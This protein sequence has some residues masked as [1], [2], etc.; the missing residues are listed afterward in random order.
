MDTGLILMLSVMAGLII[1]WCVYLTGRKKRKDGA[2]AGATAVSAE[3][4][5]GPLTVCPYCETVN[6]GRA[7]KCP[8]CGLALK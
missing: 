6:D 4:S 1:I 7:D 8:A 5:H 2:A 3:K